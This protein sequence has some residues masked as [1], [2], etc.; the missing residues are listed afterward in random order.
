MKRLVAHFGSLRAALLLM[1]L[2]GVVVLAQPGVDWLVA[3]LALLGLSLAAALAVHPALRRQVPLFVAHAAALAVLVLGGVGRLTALDGRFELTE[4]VPF[5]GRLL[6][7]EVGP[8]HRD[9]LHRLAFHHEG[10][11]IDYAPGRKRGP[12]RN[13]VGWTDAD[14]RP[15]TAT[16]GDHR[17]L[18]LEGYRIYTSPN[19]GFAPVLRWTPDRGEPLLGA[20][21]LPSFPMLE[22]QQSNEWALPDGRALWVQLQFDDKLIDPAQP[23]RFELPRQQRL[24]VRLG[25][26]RAELEPGT[27]VALPG[28]RLR[29]EGLVT[30]MG[31]RIT[32]DPTLPWMLAAALL[33]ALA[34]GVHYALKFHAARP[35]QAAV[36]EAVDG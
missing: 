11:E 14:G 26:E 34:L 10:F 6:D 18:K 7:G 25:A 27:E 13:T 28:G 33:A 5:E 32:G 16:I 31:Y 36:P 20:L 22:L 21:H 19:K 2:L 15:Q 12:T 1:A 4:G 17:P 24:V 23:A 3:P 30:W 35:R 8:W 9:R 29:Y